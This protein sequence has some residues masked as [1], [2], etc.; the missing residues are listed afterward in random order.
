MSGFIDKFEQDQKRRGLLPNT[1]LLR[2]RQLGLYEREVGRLNDATKESIETWLDGRNVS[3]KTRSCYLTTFSAFYKS[4]IKNGWMDTDPTM[5]IDRPRVHNGMPNPMPEDDLARAIKKA[6]SPMMKCW[7]VL[8]A[9]AGLRC[10]EVCYLEAKDIHY[11]D[12]LIHIR[13]G[14]GGKERYVPLHPKITAALKAY[15]PPRDE[16]RLW[17]TVTPA[18]VSQRINRYLRSVGVSHSAHKLRHRF[19]TRAYASSGS[20]IL[21]TQRLLGHSNPTTTAGYANV[22]SEAAKAA[23]MNLDGPMELEDDDSIDQ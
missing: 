17:P 20:D 9:Y 23:V 7:L 13:Y 19:G 11:A 6:K 18:S 5:K 10:Q 21:T 1:M 12:G 2:G 4:G 22:S 14:K 15:K 16:G 3:A 8:E